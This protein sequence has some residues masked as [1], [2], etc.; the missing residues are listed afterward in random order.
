[1]GHYSHT[2]KKKKNRPSWNAIVRIKKRNIINERKFGGEDKARK[3]FF[4]KR[5]HWANPEES[6]F[7]FRRNTMAQELKLQNVT[8]FY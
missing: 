7:K 2:P 4:S 8:T 5:Y 3:I 1:M 6:K